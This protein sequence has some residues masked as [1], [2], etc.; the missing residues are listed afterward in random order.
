MSMQMDPA[1]GHFSVLTSE[2]PTSDPHTMQQVPKL[3]SVVV[4]NVTADETAFQRSLCY[5]SDQVFC[6]NFM[7]IKVLALNKQVFIAYTVFKK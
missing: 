6:E 2:K 4:F 1:G 3:T 5:D 7:L